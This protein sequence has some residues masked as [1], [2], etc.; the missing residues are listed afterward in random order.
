MQIHRCGVAVRACGVCWVNNN[1]TQITLMVSVFCSPLSGSSSQ[2]T[3]CPLQPRWAVWSS[4]QCFVQQL[5]YV[6]T[7]KHTAPK[8]EYGRI[9]KRQLSNSGYRPLPQNLVSLAWSLRIVIKLLGGSGTDQRSC[10]FFCILPLTMS[11]AELAPCLVFLWQGWRNA[12]FSVLFD[13][14][15]FISLVLGKFA[16]VTPIFLIRKLHVY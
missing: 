15:L 1:H 12:M 4:N 3:A 5:D 14:F 13:L 2:Q 8:A 11:G 16:E 10:H 9:L 7:V 6:L